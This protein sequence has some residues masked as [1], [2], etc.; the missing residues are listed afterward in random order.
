MCGI[1]GALTLSN[2]G[3]GLQD[4]K[5]IHSLAMLATLRGT[6]GAG[7]AAGDID[8]EK[9]P[10]WAKQAETAQL[11]LDKNT[12]STYVDDGKWCIVHARAATIGAIVTAACHPFDFENVIGVHNGTV[13]AINSALPGHNCINDSET[14]YAAI[15][16]TDPTGVADILKDIDYGAYALAWYDK[17]LQALRFARNGDRPLW[18]YKHHHTWFWHSEPSAIAMA[19]A[20]HSTDPLSYRN[21]DPW[22]LNSHAILTIPVYEGEGYVEDFTVPIVPASY[23]TGWYDTVR[24]RWFGGGGYDDTYDAW[25]DDDDD[26]FTVT[27]KKDG[28]S[29][30]SS[31]YKPSYITYTGGS[32]LNQSWLEP[33]KEGIHGVLKSF[34]GSEILPVTQKEWDDTLRKLASL[35]IPARGVR[36]VTANESLF[37]TE[38]SFRVLELNRPLGIAYGAVYLRG[39]GWVPVTGLLSAAQ[40]KAMAHM[41]PNELALSSKLPVVQGELNSIKLYATGEIGLGFSSLLMYGTSVPRDIEVAEATTGGFNTHPA[42]ALHGHKP[43]VGSDWEIWKTKEV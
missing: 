41:Y 2:R 36:A 35:A 18:F 9:G 20:R 17:R 8:P 29:S 37:P 16:A 14:I 1:T 6:D 43:E 22:A 31:N 11:S 7:I 25:W 10:Y 32:S 27:P 30:S 42:L 23:S 26:A 21:M 15:N 28:G 33:Y 24:K 4:S 5:I 13:S 34:I 19:I 12:L 39:W 3:F 38:V 40:N